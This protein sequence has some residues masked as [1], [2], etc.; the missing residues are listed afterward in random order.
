MTKHNACIAIIS[1][2]SKCLPQCLFSL[3]KNFNDKY[4]Y[5]VYV[6]YFDDIYDSSEYRDYIHRNLGANIHFRS[7]PYETPKH[8]KEEEM[9]YNRKDLSYVSGGEFTIN[10]KGYLHMCNFWLNFHGYPNTEFDKYDYM[11]SHDDEAGYKKPM[12]ENPFDVITDKGIDMGA[13]ITGQRL[14]NGK[15]RQGHFD[16]RIGLWDFVKSFLKENNVR[17]K[18]NVLNSIVDDEKGSDKFHYLPWSDTYVLNLKFA[19]TDLWN[20]WVK[21]VNDSGGIY[22]YRWGDNELISLFAMIYQDIPMYN[23]G[24]VHNGFHDQGM[25]RLLQ[26]NDLSGYAPSVKDIKK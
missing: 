17:P 12:V 3:Y 22:K 24:Y 8:I 16:T 2:R 20:K 21:A 25:F 7:I 1:S 6:F 13:Y 14:S 23:L 11:M 5:P 26:S 4:D 19:K 18:S 10:R 15:P 9:F